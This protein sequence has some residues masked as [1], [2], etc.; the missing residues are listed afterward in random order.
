MWQTPS[1]G[2]LVNGFYTSPSA[3]PAGTVVN[4]AATD[5]ATGGSAS[6]QVT[7]DQNLPPANTYLYPNSGA[8]MERLFELGF[9]YSSLYEVSAYQRYLLFRTSSASAANACYIHWSPASNV[10]RLGNDAGDGFA[11]MAPMIPNSPTVLSNSQCEVVMGQSKQGYLG[12]TQTAPGWFILQTQLRF[13]RAFEGTKKS[14]YKVDSTGGA[15][16][17]H[18]GFWTI[19]L[20]ANL[21]LDD[22]SLMSG[23]K[24]YEA[25][26]SITAADMTVGGDA[27]VSLIGGTYIRLA[28]EFRA[29]AGTAAITFR[30]GTSD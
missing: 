7:L 26:S 10:L 23:S 20:P 1:I 15:P 28:P 22:V 16:W 2:T 30:A 21:I 5:P 9:G 6:A 25:T 29:T 24:M 19:E 11:G 17:W 27:Q 4:I 12:G 3:F 13:K 14:F 18:M 8:G